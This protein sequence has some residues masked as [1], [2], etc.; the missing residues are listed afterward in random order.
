MKATRLALVF[1]AGVVAG[2]MTA[3]PPAPAQAPAPAVTAHEP[4]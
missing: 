1:A 4:P 3:G 2:C